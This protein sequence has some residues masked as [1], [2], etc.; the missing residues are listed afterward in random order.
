VGP[1]QQAVV[2]AIV[3]GADADATGG[4]R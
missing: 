3:N 2:R 1:L 4:R